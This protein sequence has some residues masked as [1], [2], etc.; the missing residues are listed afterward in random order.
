MISQVSSPWRTILLPALVGGLAIAAAAIGAMLVGN[1]G[2]IDGVNS[3][4]E[5]LS[6]KSGSFFSGL[7]P[8]GFALAAGVAAAFNPCGFAMLPAYMGL[9]MGSHDEQDHERHLLEDLGRALLVGGSVTAGFVV[10]FGVAGTVIA[11]T[12]AAKIVF[13]IK[14]VTLEEPPPVDSVV[15]RKSWP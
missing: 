8:L 6:G 2:G 10:L 1:D 4:V 15:P 3:I 12:A 5:R 7:F 9:Y 14:M 13:P 11:S